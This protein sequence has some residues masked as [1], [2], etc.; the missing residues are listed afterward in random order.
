M[1]GCYLFFFAA[2]FFAG[3]IFP[4]CSGVGWIWRGRPK[5]VAEQPDTPICSRSRG[6]C[7]EKSAQGYQL[8]KYSGA[9]PRF[10]LILHPKLGL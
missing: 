8:E 6:V 5:L 4:S 10:H 1:F 2:F 9:F 7:Q 3:M